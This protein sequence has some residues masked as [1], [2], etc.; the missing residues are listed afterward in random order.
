MNKKLIGLFLAVAMIASI[1]AGCTAVAPAAAPAA[2][3]APTREAPTVIRHRSPQ[4]QP[5]PGTASE[6]PAPK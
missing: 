1:I 2:A 3:P 6:R 4:R 5:K